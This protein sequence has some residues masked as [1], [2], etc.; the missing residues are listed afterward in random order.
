[1]NFPKERSFR[2]KKCLQKNNFF[3]VFCDVD[4]RHENGSENECAVT[5]KQDHKKPVSIIHAAKS[6]LGRFPFYDSHLFLAT[7]KRNGLWKKYKS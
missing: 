2:N 7:N 6:D 1:M 4:S 5:E 3:K